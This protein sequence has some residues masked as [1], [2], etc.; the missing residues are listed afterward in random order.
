MATDPARERFWTDLKPQFMIDPQEIYLNSGSFGSLHRRTFD[1]F[2]NGLRTFELNPTMNHRVFWDLADAAHA[3][4]GGLLGAPGEDLAF[5]SNVTASMNMAILGLD[6]QPGDEIVASDHEYG[7]IDYCMHHAEQRWGLAVRRAPIPRPPAGP[8]DIVDAFAAAITER[9]RLLVCSH[10][11]SR[12][13]CI[14]PIRTL[15]ELA[16]ERGALL[17]SDGAHAPGM[18]PLDL[19]DSGCDLYGGNCHKWLCSP[20]GVGFLYARPEV[21]ERLHHIVVGWGYRPEGPTRGDDGGLLIGAKPFMWGLEQWGSR[22]LPSLAALP[23]A[24][25]V[26]QQIG[27]ERIAARGRQLTAYLRQRLEA[28]GWARCLAPSAP[29]MSGSLT[30]YH[31]TG[32]GDLDLR[33]RL[34]ERYRITAPAARE[35]DRHWLRVST[36]LY[37]TFAEVDALLGALEELRV[38]GAAA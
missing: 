11:F 19:A 35:G 33:E 1:A 18:I 38:S 22:D 7:S 37:N 10:I 12:T 15:A 20:K 34:Y 5:T 14:A 3:S 31:L 13:G 8:Q 26:Q 17:A 27:R 4:L 25:D 24:V 9:T 6:W 28:T 16:H 30:A 23:V 2:V 21:Q 36:H 32:F 29:G